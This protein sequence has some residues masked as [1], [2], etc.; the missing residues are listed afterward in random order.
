MFFF[1]FAKSFPRQ[2]DMAIVDTK[3]SKTSWDNLQ[4]ESSVAHQ[5]IKNKSLVVQNI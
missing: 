5:Q 2:H 3:S 4:N 1:F